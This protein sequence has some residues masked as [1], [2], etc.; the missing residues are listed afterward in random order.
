MTP[1]KRL[2]V[3]CGAT[4][5]GKSAVAQWI[6]ER[7]GAV[8][9]SADSMLVYRGMDVGTAKPTAAERGRVRYFGLDCVEPAASFSTGDWLVRVT[10][11]LAALPEGT[12]VIVA[13]GTGLYIRAFFNGLDAAPSDASLR[14]RF[15]ALYE[16]GGLDALAAEVAARGVEVPEGDRRNPR[17]LIRALERSEAARV[18][19]GARSPSAHIAASACPD[20]PPPC[21]VGSPQACLGGRGGGPPPPRPLPPA[22]AAL[23]LPPSFT[24]RICCL[25][26]ARDLLAGRIRRRIEK[27]FADGLV[28]EAL[29]C[30]GNAPDGAPTASGAIGYAEALAYHRGEIGKE[31]A[32]ARIAARTRQLAKRQETWFR[33]QLTA[34]WITVSPDETPQSVAMR[35]L[36]Q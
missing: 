13:G 29:R 30:F 33:H 25:A 19:G 35:L 6:A 8:V 32:V 28:E 34:Q 3:V 20:S 1:S 31:E 7:T 27:M 9:V 5:T 11:E 15:T 16:A 21:G 17:R 23:R 24:P 36:A 12:P 2:L 22:V 26:M 14:A 18:S 10:A 4:A